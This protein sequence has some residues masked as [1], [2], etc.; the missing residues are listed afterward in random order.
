MILLQL[1]LTNNLTAPA[2]D[3]FTPRFC[4]FFENFAFSLQALSSLRGG[5]G[6]FFV[7]DPS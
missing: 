2:N 7:A 6:T 5:L 4:R 1:N 3:S